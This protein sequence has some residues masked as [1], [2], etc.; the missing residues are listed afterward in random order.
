MYQLAIAVFS[1]W[2]GNGIISYYLAPMLETIGI[3]KQSDQTLLN[4]LLAIWNFAI[5][6]TAS[7]LVERVGRRPMFIVSTVG[8]FFGFAC[9]TITSAVYAYDNKN[10]AA[11]RTTVAMIFIFNAYVSIST[12]VAYR[13]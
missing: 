6:V 13:S 11:G 10:T 7:L 3:D 8:M 1:Q 9:V 2:S 4:G 5:A 12:S